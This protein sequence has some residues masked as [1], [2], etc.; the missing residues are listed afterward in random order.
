MNAAWQ[1]RMSSRE[2]G[3][4]L[5]KLVLLRQIT[6]STEEPRVLKSAMPSL[7]RALIP[8]VLP[9]VM[10]DVP[11]V[12]EFL[13]APPPQL[14]LPSR[15]PADLPAEGRAALAAALHGPLPAAKAPGRG[16][17]VREAVPCR[18]DDEEITRL[19]GFLA[20]VDDLRGRQ[21]RVYPLEY[22]LALLLAAGTA[23][24]GGLDAAA[25]WAATA[26]AELLLR[27]GAPL[28]R[29]GK[30]RRPDAGTIRRGLTGCDQGQYDDALCAWQG[31]RARA[32]R[33]GMRRHLRIDGKALRGAAPRGGHAADAAIR[34][35]GRRHHRRPAPGG[36]RENE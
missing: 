11:A 4:P 23:G 18:W 26:P 34:D 29:D 32:L 20:T 30:P 24:D 22:L 16:E 13:P 35:L 15:L 12:P 9:A 28:D 36:H 31:A 3:V 33:P 17:L 6:V 19:R 2:C 10:P 1:R 8:D 14:A 25:E 27:L 5:G 7:C 21:G